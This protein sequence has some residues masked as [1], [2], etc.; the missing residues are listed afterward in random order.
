MEIKKGVKFFLI[1]TLSN[2]FLIPIIYVISLIAVLL[3][4]GSYGYT[5]NDWGTHRSNT[6]MQI[7]GGIVIG[8]GTGF[9]QMK[10]LQKQFNISKNWITSMVVGFALA[11]IIA[12][13]VLMQSDVVRG[14]LT[15]INTTNHFPEALIFALAGLLIGLFQWSLL[16]KYYTRSIFWIL[17]S[18]IGWSICIL[19]TFYSQI[20]FIIGTTFYG[21]LTGFTLVWVLKPIDSKT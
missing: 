15:I 14:K 21:A 9:L 10:L 12:G 1:W 5:M 20:A 17:S 18:M 6:M 16:R 19:I 8:L 4:H 7:A 2:G 3:V 11:E 13:I